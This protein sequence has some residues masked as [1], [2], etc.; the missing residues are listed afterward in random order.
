MKD[1]FLKICFEAFSK[2]SFKSDVKYKERLKIEIQEI[3]KQN[4]WAYFVELY[5]KNIKFPKNIN[6]LLIAYLL[7]IVEDF[8]ITKEPL[9]IWSDFADAD[10]DTISEIRDYLK[11]IWAPAT[12]GKEYVANIA[13]HNTFGIKQALQD[14]ADVLGKDRHEAMLISKKIDPKDEDNKAISLDEAIGL[15]PELKKYCEDNPDVAEAVRKISGRS[16]SMGKHAGGLVISSVPLNNYIPI[17]KDNDGYPMS[18][19]V[20]GQA[21][22]DLSPMGLVKYDLLV[23]TNLMQVAIACNLVKTRHNL[24]NICA[25]PGRGDWSDIA[26]LD[27]P[28]AMAMANKGELKCIFQFDKPVVRRMAREGGVDSFNDLVAYTSLNRPPTLQAGADKQYIKRKKGL[29]EYDRHPILDPILGD[30][31]GILLYQEQIMK[32]LNAVGNVPLHECEIIRK[33]ISKKKIDMFK[34]Y[35]EYFITNGQKILGWTEEKVK[36]LWALIELFSGYGF[37][38]CWLKDSLIYLYDGSRLTAKDLYEKFD[39]KQDIFVHSIDKNQKLVPRKIKNVFFNGKQKVFK[40]TTSIGTTI[41]TTK[42]H[43]YLTFNGYKKLSNLKVG[44]FIAL[45]KQVNVMG[46]RQ[47]T[48]NELIVLAGIIAEGNTCYSGTIYFYNDDLVLINDFIKAARDFKDTKPRIYQRPDGKRYEVAC[49]TGKLGSRRRCGLYLWLESLGMANSKADVK[50]LPDSI[51]TVTD[52]EICLLLGRMWCG[53]GFIHCEDCFYPYYATSSEK[54]AEQ[55]RYLLLRLG[56][57]SSF[58]KKKFKYRE[59]FKIGYKISLLGQESVLNFISKI[60]PYCLNKQDQIKAIT[61][62]F[63]KERGNST[64]DIIPLDVLS[65]ID[66]A[67]CYDS[68]RKLAKATGFHDRYFC[69]WKNKRGFT[70]K[71]LRKVANILN[72]EELND[73]VNSDIFWDKIVSIEANGKDDTYDLEV[74][75]NHNLIVN[76]V[77]TSNSHAVAYSYVSS[78]LLYLKAHY[79]LEFFTAILMYEDDP[80]KVK[81]YINEAKRMGIKVYPL[82]INKSKAK[83][84][85][86][87]E[88]IYCGFFNIKGI[89]LETA[90]RIVANQPY[91][92][93][94]DF[95]DRFGFDE[96]VIKP[97]IGLKLFGDHDPLELYKYYQ[98]YKKYKRDL[99]NAQ[100]RIQ[101]VKVAK[102]EELKALIP[103]EFHVNFA[104]CDEYIE[105]L[106]ELDN[107]NKI[108]VVYNR[109]KRSCET[110]EK[111]ISKGMEILDVEINE[112]V[113]DL[114]KSKESIESHF[115]GFLWD[116]PLDKSPDYNGFSFNVYRNEESIIGSVE[117]LIKEVNEKISKNNN[118]Y[119]LMKVEDAFGEEQFVQ[120]WENDWEIFN[121]LLIEGN[122]VRLTLS[123]PS[124]GFSSY[125]LYSPPKYMRWKLPSKEYDFRVILMRKHEDN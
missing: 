71:S 114:Y 16:K 77:I 117:V 110:Q 24:L 36:E 47:F 3:S 49:N 18:A 2:Q 85:I 124:A 120:V 98:S 67:N 75:E 14:M 96:C 68:L 83:F 90:N 72:S 5:E 73:I 9:Y 87:G 34:D 115:Y 97:F 52:E 28:K 12:F 89:G 69:Y 78:R 55:V 30:T 102:T 65:K 40:V 99:Q 46:Q 111:K 8:D 108:M 76:G 22:Q 79:T 48:D 91:T 31:Y 13:N 60:G 62:Y 42:T 63:S 119:Y 54:L 7:G 92:S 29:E 106:S 32:I 116:H 100:E 70:R 50:T 95:M 21:R 88:D 93:F 103:E 43:K 84:S 105:S 26:Y 33:A 4:E 101:E 10:C 53:D 23:V 38:Q 122:L 37:N 121:D 35:K 15:Y 107:F 81:D 25:L 66:K 58:H 80:V 86:V 125:T 45:P 104:F 113:L 74:E 94:T 41:T 82:D 57:V 118:R 109:Y 27:D 123:A 11:N 61:E 112:K 56:I 39:G 51:F 59:N 17:V 6:N 19:W 64:K 1:K 20:E 44:D